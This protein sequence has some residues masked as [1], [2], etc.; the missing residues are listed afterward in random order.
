MQPA[1]F[2]Y[3]KKGDLSRTHYFYCRVTQR[4]PVAR[5]EFYLRGGHLCQVILMTASVTRAH[6]AFSMLGTVIQQPFPALLEQGLFLYG[7]K[8]A[9]H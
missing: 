3:A 1:H 8:G 9:L 6:C 2:F 7:L 5:R 4:S